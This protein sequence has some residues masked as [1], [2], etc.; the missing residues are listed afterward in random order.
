[1]PKIYLPAINFWLA[2]AFEQ[3]ALH[4]AAKDWFAHSAP[5]GSEVAGLSLTTQLCTF[6]CLYT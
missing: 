1:M 2:M 6:F 4:S 3:H 5:D